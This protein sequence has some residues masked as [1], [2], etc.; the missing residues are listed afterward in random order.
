M[1]KSLMLISFAFIFLLSMSIVSANFFDWLNGD[2]TRK[3]GDQGL[4]PTSV[5]DG[6]L[7]T[8]T[9]FT[10]RTP[11]SGVVSECPTGWTST[12]AAGDGSCCVKPDGGTFNSPFSSSQKLREKQRVG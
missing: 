1:K 5:S 11:K 7:K 12:E 8:R 4:A 9:S 6:S 2:V 10:T 3:A